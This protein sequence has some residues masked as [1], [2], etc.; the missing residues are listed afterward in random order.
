MRFV[1]AV[2]H[3][4]VGLNLIIEMRVCCFFCFVFSPRNVCMVIFKLPVVGSLDF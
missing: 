4:N 3:G 2:S 1:P